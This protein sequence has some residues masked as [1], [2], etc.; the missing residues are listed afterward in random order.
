MGTFH[1]YPI[2]SSSH[3]DD[4]FEIYGKMDRKELVR[5]NQYEKQ[6][7]KGLT[8]YEPSCLKTLSERGQ[9]GFTL[10][11]GNDNEWRCLVAAW[12]MVGRF[13]IKLFLLG[14]CRPP[15]APAPALDKLS[16][17]NLTTLPTH[18]GIKYVKR[19]PCC[20][21]PKLFPPAD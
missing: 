8:C 4:F 7:Q 2:S 1:K 15:D 17:P 13:P 16:D 12:Q 10:S 18:P 3:P 5:K 20:D 14:G 6:S 19:S 21:H 11:P 9:M